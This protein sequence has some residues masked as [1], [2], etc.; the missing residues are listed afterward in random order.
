MKYNIIPCPKAELNLLRDL[1]WLYQFITMFKVLNFNKCIIHVGKNSIICDVYFHLYNWTIYFFY[2]AI[3][4][5]KKQFVG[6]S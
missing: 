4:M 3:I 6:K 5:V 2:T 1:P